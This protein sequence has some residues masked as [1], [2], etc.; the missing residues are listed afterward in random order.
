MHPEVT[1]DKKGYCYKCG[2]ELVKKRKETNHSSNNAKLSEYKSLFIIVGLIFFVSLV[3]SSDLMT[4][5]RNFMAGFFIVFSGFK[6]LDLNGFAEGYSTY[7]LLARKWRGYGYVY[8]FVELLLGILLIRNIYPIYVN[9]FIVVLMTFSG[10]GVLDSIS[11]K[12]KFK[13]A[14]LGTVIDLPLT[15][16]TLVEDFGMAG[17]AVFMLLAM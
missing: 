6:L 14:C 4:L 15:T 10:L 13:C 8:P 3:L 16:V 12:R 17:M 1:L 7:D 9:V 5:M 11:K 2:M